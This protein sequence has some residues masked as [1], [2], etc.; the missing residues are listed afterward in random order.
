[1]TVA[2]NHTERF[3]FMEIQTGKLAGAN[4]AII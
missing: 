3:E 2:D 4:F 1:M